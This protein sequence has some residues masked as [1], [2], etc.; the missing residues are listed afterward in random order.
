[1]FGPLHHIYLTA[2]G[3]YAHTA[4]LG[5]TAQIGLRIPVAN[6]VSGP[7]KG[8]IWT[9]V[10]NGDVTQETGV[11]TGLHGQLAETWTARAG[12]IGSLV[13]ADPAFQVNIAEHLWTFLD[14]IKA[15]VS[16]G[17]RWTHMKVAPIGIS[18]DYESSAATYSL[19]SPLAGSATTMLPPQIALAVS[20]RAPIIGQRGRGRVYLP[21]ITHSQV[22]S[23]GKVAS[24]FATTVMNNFKTLID[25]IQGEWATGDVQPI[26]S[27]FS[28]GAADVI[29]PSEIR[30]GDRFDTQQRRRRQV[31]EAYSQV[32]L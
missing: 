12:A 14:S 8:S 1:M 5:E 10:S 26:V 25:N 11:T 3:E 19:S 18:G 16:S 4:W 30:V 27:V 22:A 31:P 7:E 17:F 2:H 21:A 6:R 20:L 9:P 23:D 15:Y 28:P 32:A 13:N 24:T 29:R